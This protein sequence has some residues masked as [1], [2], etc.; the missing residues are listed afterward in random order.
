MHIR[1]FIALLLGFWMA[2]LLVAAWIVALSL[3]V[4]T[5]ISATPP[6]EISRMLKDS[7]DPTV[8]RFVH[9]IASEICR[10]VFENWGWLEM[11]LTTFI[12]LILFASRH[13]KRFTILAG[14]CVVAAVA[15]HA[16][17]TPQVVS[18]G[19]LLDFHGAEAASANL[20]LYWLY[21][22]LGLFRLACGC[23]LAGM[24]LF[25]GSRNHSLRSRPKN[26]HAIDDTD[27]RHV[28]R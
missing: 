17:L 22:S 1:R 6:V 13:S 20:A 27:D 4:S 3:E 8:A 2:G 21:G 16:L 19:R 24:L 5:R 26:I 11:G 23:V 10:S 18:R 28:D 9:F 15:S 25:R 12:L 14:V 7:R